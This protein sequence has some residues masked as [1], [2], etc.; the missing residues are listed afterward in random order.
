MSSRGARLESTWL[1][2]SHVS[3]IHLL[4]TH[5][6]ACSAAAGFLAVAFKTSATEHE[7]SAVAREE[8]DASH[9]V[10]AVA[11]L[12]TEGLDTTPCGGA[13]VLPPFD[14]TD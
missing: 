5:S 8:P 11:R 1:P 12:T 3:A 13:V 9:D 10:D 6:S 2:G 4:D 7:A 14:L